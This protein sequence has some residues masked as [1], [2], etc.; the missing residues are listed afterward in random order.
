MKIAVLQ[1]VPFETP[2]AIADWAA[3]RQHSLTLYTLFNGMSL[4]QLDAFDMLV[5]LGGP[6]SVHDEHEHAWLAGE[7]T[8]IANAMR[9]KKYVVGICL[10]AQLIAAALGAA[11]TRN[12]VKEIGWFPVVVEDKAAG[13]P[14]LRGLN[15]AMNV[16]HWHGETFALPEGAINLMSSKVCQHQAFLY[17]DHILGLQFH[18]EMQEENIGNI[19]QYCSAEIVQPTDT[20]QSAETMLSQPHAIAACTGAL[21]SLLDNLVAAK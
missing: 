4:P 19:I 20:I 14:V 16:F 6:M 11:V 7:K 13:H 15:L 3:A 18:L 8:L 17:K 9:E 12:P 5:V 2:G 21:F 10:G 1:H